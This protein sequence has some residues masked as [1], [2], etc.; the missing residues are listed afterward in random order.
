MP[1]YT[2]SSVGMTW[3]ATVAGFRKYVIPTLGRAMAG[4]YAF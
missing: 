4:I 2:Q 1:T 3:E